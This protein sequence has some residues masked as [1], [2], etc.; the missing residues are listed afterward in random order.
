MHQNTRTY[1]R[2]YTCIAIRKDT[3][4]NSVYLPHIRFYCVPWY[5]V[6]LHTKKSLKT[7]ICV[8]IRLAVV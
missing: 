3:A 4:K 7:K 5:F 8:L 2:T 1:I 6:R